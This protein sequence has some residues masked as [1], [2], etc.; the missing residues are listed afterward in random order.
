MCSG[1]IQ[2]AT[3]VGIKLLKKRVQAQRKR[4]FYTSLLTNQYLQADI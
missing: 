3:D 2:A 4:K 1:I